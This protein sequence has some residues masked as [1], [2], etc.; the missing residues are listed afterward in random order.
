[1]DKQISNCILN[2]VLAWIHLLPAV[3]AS[4]ITEL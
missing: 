3:E 1:L 2:N 4:V